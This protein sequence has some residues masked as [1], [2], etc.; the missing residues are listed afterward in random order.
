ML[1]RARIGMAAILVLCFLSAGQWA[2]AGRRRVYHVLVINSFQQGV[3]WTQAQMSAIE[4]VLVKSPLDIELHIDYM[5]TKRIRLDPRYLEDKFELLSDEFD[6]LHFDVVI[7]S[8]IDALQFLLDKGDLLF[9]K[10]P[11]IVCG[12]STQQA[13]AISRH[14]FYTGLFDDWNLRDNIKLATRLFPGTRQVVFTHDQTSVG[15]EL[16]ASA[17][18]AAQDFPDLRFTFISGMPMSEIEEYVRL[19]PPDAVLLPLAFTIDSAGTF[20]VS[21]TAMK[22]ITSASAAP[23]FGLWH[24]QL[25][26]GIVGGLLISEAEQGRLAA[27]MAVRILQGEDVKDVR[28]L[29]RTPAQYTFDFRELRRFDVHLSALPA[30]SVVV[31]RPLSFFAVH[32]HVLI[33]SA[34]VVGCL[35]LVVTVLS[36]NILRRKRAEENLCASE[37]RYRLLFERSPDMVVVLRNERF[38]AVNAT[39]LSMLGYKP[40]E[41]IGLTPWD[42][43]PPSQPDGKSSE[44]EARRYIALAMEAGTQSFHWTH[45]RKD[46][47][48]VLCD[49]HLA[50]YLVCGEVLLQAIVRDVT[51]RRRAEEEKRALEKKLEQ[52]KRSFYRETILSVTDGK[53]D[54]CD[55]SAVKPYIS[56]ALMCIEVEDAFAAPAAREEVRRVCRENGLLG[57]RFDQFMVGVGEAI[58][59]AVKHGEECRVC[60]GVMERGV[61]VAVTDHGKGIASLILPRAVLSRSFSTKPS[62][63]LGYSIMLDVADRILLATDEHG[64]TVILMKDLVETPPETMLKRLLERLEDSAG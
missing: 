59:N 26:D 29:T 39:V 49:V 18:A 5:H 62:L 60:A 54:I 11:V 57:E 33:V 1:W 9:P 42:I 63:G 48:E 31:N 47:T 35:L 25:R 8:G 13:A 41:V 22:R 56:D 43:S 6:K 14:R 46:G 27:E 19:L 53:L 24:F 61:W 38:T 50:A 17:R 55:E 64:T 52:Q 20:F 3:P 2:E 30:G 51:A 16:A 21:D 44:E 32:A 15:L 28:M 34:L 7:C 36:K 37:E 4:S 23:A 58:T 45:S 40:E 10:T 12:V